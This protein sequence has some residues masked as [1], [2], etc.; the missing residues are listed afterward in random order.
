MELKPYDAEFM[1]IIMS[2]STIVWSAISK[3]NI[4]LGRVVQQTILT[5][6]NQYSR[7]IK[8]QNNVFIMNLYLSGFTHYEQLRAIS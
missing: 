7:G 2:S 4:G 1:Q 8:I 5:A 3:V 6:Y